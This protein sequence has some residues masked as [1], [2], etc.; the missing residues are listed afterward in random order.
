MR[1]R[2]TAA[3]FRFHAEWS[4]RGL[5]TLKIRR[6]VP[7]RGISSAQKF[8]SHDRTFLSQLRRA[9]KNTLHSHSPAKIPLDWNGATQFQKSVWRALQK[10]PRGQTRSYTQ[11][12]RAIGK[13][14]AARAVGAACGANPTIV[15]VPCHRVIAANGSLGGFSCGLALKKK[16]LEQEESPQKV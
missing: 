12:A 5:R 11:I 2:F 8:S 13:P 3:G 9:I 1:A 10:I 4:P 14:K 7:P 6:G 15:L 16:L